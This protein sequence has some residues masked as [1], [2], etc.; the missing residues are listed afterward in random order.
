MLVVEHT[1]PGNGAQD[2]WKLTP[3]FTLNY[4][5]RVN[6]IRA[7]YEDSG[8]IV[9]FDSALRAICHA[10]ASSAHGSCRGTMNTNT[11]A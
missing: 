5:V 4:G 10:C 6:H 9:V 1:A 7:W 2:Q 8:R 11:A 3:G